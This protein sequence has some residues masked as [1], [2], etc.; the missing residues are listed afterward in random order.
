MSL[1]FAIALLK[2]LGQIVFLG[3][4]SYLFVRF[5][6]QRM[7]TVDL[8][9]ANTVVFLAAVVV[10]TSLMGLFGVLNWSFLFMMVVMTFLIGVMVYFNQVVAAGWLFVTRPAHSDQ[11]GPHLI[12]TPLLLTFCAI[13]LVVGLKHLPVEHDVMTYHL[14]FPARWIQE[15]IIFFIFS[16]FGDLAPTY[17]PANA[18]LTFVFW[19][20]PFSNDALSRVGQF[21]FLFMAAAAVFGL[22]L[23]R[24]LSRN[25]AVI[26][27]VLAMLTPMVF[28]QGFSAEVDL[29]MGATWVAALY[30]LDSYRQE[31]TFSNAFLF[32]ASLGL[33]FGTKFVALPFGAFVLIPF[34]YYAV[35]SVSE[36][37]LRPL[38]H[39]ALAGAVSFVTGGFWYC[40]NWILTGNPLFPLDL[41]PLFEGVYN[42]AAMMTSP[43]HIPQ[44]KFLL[45]IWIHAY[46]FWMAIAAVAGLA[47]T[48]VLI[49]KKRVGLF[50]AYVL[51]I[52]WLLAVTHFALT[53]YNSQYR[54]L[55]PAVL[56]SFLPIGYLEEN[57][58][59]RWV[60]RGFW[61]LLLLLS[62]LGIGKAFTLGSV[63]LVKSAL[64]PAGYAP[65]VILMVAL[66]VIT[67]GLLWKWRI[68]PILRMELVFCLMFFGAV[69]LSWG[70]ATS[71]KQFLAVRGN[72][73]REYPVQA[74]ALLESHQASFRIAYAGNNVPYYLLGRAW[75]HEAFYVNV[76]GPQEHVLH[77]FFQDCT[78]KAQCPDPSLTDKPSPLWRVQD[79]SDW[80]HNLADSQANF[81]YVTPLNPLDAAGIEHD[82]QQYPIER[83]WADQSPELFAPIWIQPNARIYRINSQKLTARLKE[84]PPA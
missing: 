42:R 45:P 30:F 10:I 5:T 68:V 55:L 70:P 48:I 26:P 78:K 63:P 29:A 46:G 6:L 47:I 81:L 64:L 44:A 67:Y 34:V 82:A 8:L 18:E 14:F 83:F 56:C 41:P 4:A 20:L 52:P 66:S 33:C 27:V 35:R 74:W 61:G 19:S 21:P 12:L 84:S 13:A 75:Q 1:H 15:E 79:L 7:Q 32:G 76:G 36:N 49:V 58:K 77:D 72:M 57:E 53:P 11:P 24:G 60:G 62:I 16:V 31:R 3:F 71:Q 51:L 22:A 38:A 39:L 25:A 73:P 17:A 65:V 50:D 2:V 28:K 59:N 54:F 80:L 40:R 69:V 9:L 43:F 37:G 23:N